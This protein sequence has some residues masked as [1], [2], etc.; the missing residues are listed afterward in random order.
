M[1]RDDCADGAPPKGEGAFSSVDPTAATESARRDAD[2]ISAVASEDIGMLGALVG[3]ERAGLISPNPTIW[4]QN[5]DPVIRRKLARAVQRD[6][7][8]MKMILYLAL[9]RFYLLKFRLK[10]TAFGINL[11]RNIIRCGH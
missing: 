4:A 9:L 1:L 5:I 7:Q 11:R 2:D 6:V 3:N 8:R 10:I